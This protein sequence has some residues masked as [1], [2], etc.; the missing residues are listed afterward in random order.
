MLS[1]GRRCGESAEAEEGGETNGRCTG[2]S[3]DLRGTERGPLF[4]KKPASN[5]SRRLVIGTRERGK[6][7]GRRVTSRRDRASASPVGRDGSR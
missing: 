6:V 4:V 3:G 5:V 7:A 1:D 2:H